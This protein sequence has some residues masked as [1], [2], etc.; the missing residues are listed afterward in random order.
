MTQRLKKSKLFSSSFKRK[1]LLKNENLG[2]LQPRIQ[3]LNRDLTE[4]ID[5]KEKYNKIIKNLYDYW[6]ALPPDWIERC[7]QTVKAQKKCYSCGQETKN[8]FVSHKVPILK[9]GNHK[10]QNLILICK[11]CSSVSVPDTQP[12]G[13][14]QHFAISA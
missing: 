5:S 4:L 11:Q 12:A 3:Y 14:I 1:V 7:Q 10:A 8:L 6:P 9:G 2:S 13:I